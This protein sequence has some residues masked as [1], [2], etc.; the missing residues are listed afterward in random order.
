MKSDEATSD[1]KF[2]IP[3]TS[4][5]AQHVRSF[6]LKLPEENVGKKGRQWQEKE[7]EKLRSLRLAIQRH[8]TLRKLIG[9]DDAEKRLKTLQDMSANLHADVQPFERLL[10]NNLIASHRLHLEAW[11][12]QINKELAEWRLLR[13]SYHVGV[14]RLR[15]E[16]IEKYMG[17]SVWA[18][19][20]H[21]LSKAPII[22]SLIGRRRTISAGLIGK[23]LAF[24]PVDYRPYQSHQRRP[25]KTGADLLIGA[26]LGALDRSTQMCRCQFICSVVEYRMKTDRPRREN[27]QLAKWAH[28]DC[29]RNND[30]S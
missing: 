29:K 9:E 2:E 15:L 8:R 1:L 21:K 10:I 4:L 6:Q 11:N 18:I 23:R 22:L 3:E 24:L 14:S 30:A 27:S 12:A 16:I 13:Q 26:A 28:R 17:K 20:Y 19:D 5:V 7:N 25:V